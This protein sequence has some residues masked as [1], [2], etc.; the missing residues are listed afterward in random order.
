[1]TLKDIT[2]AF[3]TGDFE[4]S[5]PYLADD[6]EWIVVGEN[7][8]KGSEAVKNQCISVAQYFKSVITDFKMENVIADTNRVAI[9]G[10]AAFIR[11]GQIVNFVSSCDVYEF[12]S[13]NQLKKITSYCISE[14]N[15]P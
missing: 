2:I 10:T 9:N 15:K 13:N 1:M 5:F 3:S 11:N 14:N 4:A 12:N 7:K 8:L 6:V